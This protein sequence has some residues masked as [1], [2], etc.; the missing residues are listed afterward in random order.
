MFFR[1]YKY[2]YINKYKDGTTVTDE[3]KVILNKL[4]IELKAFKESKSTLDS[5]EYRRNL[6]SYVNTF[7]SISIVFSKLTY[8]NKPES[9]GGSILKKKKRKVHRSRKLLKTKKSKTSKR[10]MAKKSRKASKKGRK[11]RRK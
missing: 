5:Q 1:Y 4:L 8:E 7:K 2:F 11:T 9:S 3:D 6:N 10:K